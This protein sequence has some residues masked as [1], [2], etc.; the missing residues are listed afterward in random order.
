MLELRDLCCGYR[1]API[2]QNVSLEFPEGSITTLVGINGCGKSTL[3]KTAAGLLPPLSGQLLL[4]GRPISSF[5]PREFA[6]RVAVLPQSREVPA[7]TVEAFVA[8]GRFPWLG[9]MRKPGEKDRALCEAALEAAGIAALRHRELRT[10]SGGERQK[11]YLAMTIA[12]DTDYIFLDEPTTYL[13]IARQFEFLELVQTLHAR[14]KTIVMV[15]HDLAQA[16]QY[17][18]RVA[19]FSNGALIDCAAPEQIAA[20]GVLEQAFSVKLTCCEGHYLFSPLK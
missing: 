14:G 5:A 7:I 10:L 2:L 15:L 19:V 17:S 6:R 12:Q 3:L 9:L 11:A 20:S 13:D 8:H 16:L 4:D 1:G 18:E